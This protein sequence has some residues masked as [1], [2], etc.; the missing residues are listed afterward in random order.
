MAYRTPHERRAF[1]L[2]VYPWALAFVCAF[3]VVS[4]FDFVL[5]DALTTIDPETRRVDRSFETEDWYALLRVFGSIPLWA[6]IA[7]VIVALGKGLRAALAVLCAAALGGIGAELL[8]LVFARERPVDDAILIEGGY[9]F[10]APFSGFVDGSNLGLPSSHTAVAFAGAVALGALVP[11][12]RPLVFLLAAGCAWT[13]MISG[14]HYPSDVFMGAVV[15]ALAAWWV[16][17]IQPKTDRKY[18]L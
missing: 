13:R 2:R 17:S 16:V 1:Y 5:I 3:V 11:K 8:K 4:L 7:V 9:R 12:L 15:G 10:R 18:T 6:I 14:A